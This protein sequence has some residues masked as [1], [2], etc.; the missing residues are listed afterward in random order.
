[1]ADT[2]TTT[3]GLVKPEVGASEDTWGT[4]LNTNL[5]TIDDLLDGT[6]PISGIDIASGTISGVE[7]ILNTSSGAPTGGTVAAGE[8]VLDLTNNKLYSST[9]GT[10]VVEIGFDGQFDDGSASA[11]SIGFSS[12]TDTGFY[13]IDSGTVGFS[14]NNDLRV[15]FK[16]E[17]YFHNTPN[18]SGIPSSSESYVRVRNDSLAG[19]YIYN[20]LYSILTEETGNYYPASFTISNVAKGSIYT[21]STG[22]AYN[23]T[24]DYRLK[25]N[26]SS[27]DNAVTRI[28]SL[29]PVRFNFIEEPS[30]TVDGFIAHEVAPIVPEAVTGE[31]D[32]VDDDGNP[33]Y[34]GI[35]QAKLV[36]L[37]VAA[38]QELSARVAALEGGA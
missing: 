13:R 37:L 24:S 34:Q 29:N 36:P 25:E 33:V 22:T 16:D 26:I 23:T 9:D 31:K 12:D 5:D 17:T 27:L 38:V 14:T 19:V 4:K 10:D 21:T 20:S 18:A 1:M 30:I 32:A 15:T 8:P 6:T 3:Y 7:L 11:P 28:N 35:D 2:T